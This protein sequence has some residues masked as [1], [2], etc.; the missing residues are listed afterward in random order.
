MYLPTPS[1][2]RDFIYFIVQRTSRLIIYTTTR[3]VRH[4]FSKSIMTTENV[5]ISLFSPNI[6]I[7]NLFILQYYILPFI[8]EKAVNIK[9]NVLYNCFRRV[10]NITNNKK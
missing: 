7:I 9:T 5:I 10:F 2:F 6:T 8:R 3:I 1:A 4:T